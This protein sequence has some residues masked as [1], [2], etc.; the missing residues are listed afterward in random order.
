MGCS[1]TPHPCSIRIYPAWDMDNLYLR[2]VEEEP[3]V[4]ALSEFTA[5][6]SPSIDA[7]LHPEYLLQSRPFLPHPWLTSGSK[8]IDLERKFPRRGQVQLPH[9]AFAR[10]SGYAF[11]ISSLMAGEGN[12]GRFSD[13]IRK[14]HKNRRAGVLLSWA[15]V[16]YCR[17]PPGLRK[18]LY[19]QIPDDW[20]KWECSAGM[21]VPRP[22][23]V[24]YRE[25]LLIKG[26]SLHWRIFYSEWILNAFYSEWILN[27]TVRFITDAHHRVSCGAYPGGS[28]TTS[29]SWV[30][31]S[32]WRAFVTT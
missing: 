7:D 27:A 22:A 13:E 16:E 12:P 25:S 11:Y 32:S 31:L 4:K 3:Y 10:D 21:A 17:I 14:E 5:N 26:D 2:G 29:R 1:S 9:E 23:V 30:S 28:S 8:T 19:P 6:A 18:T 15:Q 20:A 24:T